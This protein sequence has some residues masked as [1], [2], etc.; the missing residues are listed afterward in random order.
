MNAPHDPFREGAAAAAA[1]RRRSLA[2]A[3]L[4]VLFAALVFS[5]TAVRLKQSTAAQPVA[6]GQVVR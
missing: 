4:C 5:I 6:A 1:R 2:I 3:L